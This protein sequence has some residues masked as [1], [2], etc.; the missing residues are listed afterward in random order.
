MTFLLGML[1]GMALLSG[2]AWIAALV[3]SE[4]AGHDEPRVKPS[5]HL[6]YDPL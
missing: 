6:H 5:P 4:T 1:T 3:L 2:L